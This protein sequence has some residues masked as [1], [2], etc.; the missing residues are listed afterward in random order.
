M[1]NGFISFFFD[2]EGHVKTIHKDENGLETMYEVVSDID[3]DK[4]ATTPTNTEEYFELL[5]RGTECL[6]RWL[7]STDLEVAAEYYTLYKEAD[8]L[9]DLYLLQR[10]KETKK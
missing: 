3:I 1:E 7:A 5:S 8:K 10:I 9:C 2:Q 6:R 4:K